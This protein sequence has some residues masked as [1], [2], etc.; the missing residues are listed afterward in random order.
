MKW[1]RGHL[2]FLFVCNVFLLGMAMMFAI[3]GRNLGPGNAA[4]PVS[5][6]FMAM[7]LLST[8]VGVPLASQD[9]RIK[10]LETQLKALQRQIHSEPATTS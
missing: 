2:V 8:A 3:A 1:S 6:A 7:S 5:L 10:A 4:I 9:R